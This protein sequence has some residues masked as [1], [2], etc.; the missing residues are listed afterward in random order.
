MKVRIT[1]L[2]PDCIWSDYEKQNHKIIGR[3]FTVNGEIT[4]SNQFSNGWSYATFKNDGSDI[5]SISGFKYEPVEESLK[6]CWK[7]GENPIPW[8]GKNGTGSL[9]GLVTCCNA[10]CMSIEENYTVDE[11]QSH[12][13]PE[14]SAMSELAGTIANVK[15]HSRILTYGDIIAEFKKATKGL[16]G[17]NIET[18]K[19]M[20]KINKALSP[21]K[22]SWLQKI[23]DYDRLELALSEALH[24]R[25]L[26]ATVADV[27]QERLICVQKDYIDATEMIGRRLKWKSGNVNFVVIVGNPVTYIEANFPPLDINKDE[28]YAESWYKSSICKKTDVFDWKK[29]VMQALFNFFKYYIQDADIQSMIQRDLYAKYPEL[30]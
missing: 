14:P 15:F 9:K 21:K 22:K 12:P 23:R 27:W 10:E 13:R 1:K 26:H 18:T 19:A 30:K 5:T 8:S 2:H 16:I 29:G 17:Q 28:D 24:D 6:P 25:D 20:K 4:N 3:V 7:C 11:W